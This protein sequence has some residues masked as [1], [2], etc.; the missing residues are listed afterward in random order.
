MS[1]PLRGDEIMSCRHRVMLSRAQLSDVTRVRATDEMLRR[2]HLAEEYREGVLDVLARLKGSVVARTLEETRA[3]IA[4]GEELIVRPRLDDDV[5]G[6]RRASVHALVRLGR[7]DE[8][9][10][11]APL[12]VKN[13][14]I[15][16]PSHTRELLMS[17][18]SRPA[19]AHATVQRGFNVRA[20]T[21]LTRSGIALAH[22]TRVLQAQGCG[23]EHGRV[24]LVDRQRRVWW[25]DLAASTHPRFNL[26]TYDALY[27]ERRDLIDALR[28][29]SEGSGEFPTSAYWHRECEDC[30]FRDHCRG[31]LETRDD[32]SLTHYTNFE[33]QRLLHE[34]GVDTRCD[35]AG[36]DPERARLARHAPSDS[37]SRE[38]VLAVA[39]ERLDDLIYRAR[40][41]RAGTVLRRVASDQMGCPRADVEVD[42]DME[43]DG[44]H[45]YLW[46]AYVRA[47]A[48]AREGSVVEGYHPFVSWDEPSAATEAAVFAEFWRW[49]SQLRDTCAARSL[50]FAAYCFWAQAEDGAMNRAVAAAREGG[51]T[52]SDLDAFRTHSP[53]QW[54]DLHEYAKAQL[55]TEGPLGLKVLAR[56]AGFDWRDE[57]PSGEASMAWFAAARAP[58]RR[59]AASPSANRR[60]VDGDG[61]VEV[62]VD[63]ASLDAESALDRDEAEVASWRRR[64]LE[65]NED[66]CRAT[67]ALRDWLNGP[68][69]DLAHRDDPGPW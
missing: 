68:A 37:P 47:S 15:V 9:F 43:S 45:T 62:E 39:I 21:S 69:R 53:A 54:I 2:R 17:R 67:Q 50:T 49:F 60:P 3:A 25:L 23:D 8:L 42:V 18:L 51:P 10:H 27:R 22:A 11:Y 13:S 65:Y 48:A 57:N 41:H 36:L 19:F 7:R 59:D 30:D 64:I 66:D 24:A 6:Q 34:F 28:S 12:V 35:L 33:Q 44:E 52:L 46:G 32:V 63:G 4:R 31:E 14:E 40:A 61:D 26:A 1:S 55:Q 5:A 20:T 58:A 56:A 16:E 29:W 38:A